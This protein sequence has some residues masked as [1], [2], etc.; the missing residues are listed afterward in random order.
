MTISQVLAKLEEMQLRYV[1]D[2][3]WE[4][5]GSLPDFMAEYA[6]YHAIFMSQYGDYM[7]SYRKNVA[8]VLTEEQDAATVINE[9]AD[10]PADRRS[11]AEIE[12]RVNIRISNMKGMRDNF[13]AKVEASKV[14]IS[15]MQSK[16]RAFS[17]E[18]KG[19]M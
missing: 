3:V 12:R 2:R 14:L 17:D 15:T 8:L 7:E 11:Q 9:D 5:P 13:D 1:R 19:L 4:D 6:A 10:K 18:A 16:R